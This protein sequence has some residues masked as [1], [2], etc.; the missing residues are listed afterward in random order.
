ML[1]ILCKAACHGSLAGPTAE[2]TNSG[3]EE[4]VTDQIK[5]IQIK[6]N[7][8]KRNTFISDTAEFPPCPAAHP[9]GEDVTN[10]CEDVADLL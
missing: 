1:L 10:S 6:S 8:I 2:V 3:E 7:Q 9:G 4:H 5:S